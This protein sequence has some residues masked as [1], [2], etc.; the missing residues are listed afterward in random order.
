M[1]RIS[2]ERTAGRVTVRLEGD[3]SG[4]WVEELRKV[5]DHLTGGA[6]QNGL[7]LVLDLAGVSSIDAGGLALVRDLA[8]RRLRVT[9]C[10]PYLA[11]LLKDVTDV[12]R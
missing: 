5:C 9:N 3:I 8:G 11:E 12:E 1:L 4:R 2:D 6:S 10:S 7:R